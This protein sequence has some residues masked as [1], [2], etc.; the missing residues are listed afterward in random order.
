MPR[1]IPISLPAM[2]QVDAIFHTGRLAECNDAMARMYGATDAISLV[3]IPLLQLLPPDDPRNVEYL[4][5]FIANGYH[6][7]NAV[8]HE[9]GLDGNQLIFANSLMGIIEHGCIVAA[10][11]TQRD[12]TSTKKAQAALEQSERRWRALVEL[13]PHITIQGYDVNGR[14]TFWNPASEHVFGYS[15]REAMGKTLDQLIF[16]KP[17]TERFQ[18]LLRA[19]AADGKPWGPGQ[20]EFTHADGRARV[21]MSSIFPTPG[22]DG[23]LQFV[24]MDYDVTEQVAAERDRRQLEEQLHRTQKLESLGVMAGGVAH[25]FNNLLVGVLGNAALAMSQLPGEHPAA[26]TLRNVQDAARRAA[27]LTRQL[28]AYAGK[29]GGERRPVNI[30]EVLT[31]MLPLMRSMIS[32]SIEL[33]T[34]RPDHLPSVLADPTQIE[35]VLLNLVTNAAEACSESN[36]PRITIRMQAMRIGSEV[37]SNQFI[38]GNLPEGEYVCIDVEDNGKGM[39][40]DVRNRLFDPFFSTKFTGRGLGLA[41]VLGIVRGT[42]GGISVS[43]TLGTGT[44]F[45]IILPVCHC[46]EPIRDA[47]IIEPK[48]H[49]SPQSV[50]ALVV[51]D[52][53]MVA[54]VLAL[55]LKSLG[56]N[57]DVASGGEEALLLLT[58]ASAHTLAIID[59]TMPNMSG[60][61]LASRIRALRPGMT[62]LLSSGYA[63]ES[64]TELPEG[65]VDGFVAKPFT[66]D[67][68][69]DALMHALST[70]SQQTPTS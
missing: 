54:Q 13:T 37:L 52:E 47:A 33:S 39:S 4:R 6:L 51:D 8:S 16:S 69:L 10:W 60:T 67:S 2:E 42:G 35:Q 57:V 55:S 45:R 17:V 44:F 34:S 61:E 3:G 36:R 31:P 50:H 11:G 53:P 58:A 46:I 27:E 63:A 19:M 59:V 41:V 40:V 68:L 66:P 5:Q 7:E 30:A 62:I 14:V 26:A 28:L 9:R 38:P 49:A 21:I 24:C 65:L 48:S 29:A 12:I 23:D 32:P 64:L 70:R 56:W 20:W 25:D 43:S 15:A 18:G 22:P 1:P